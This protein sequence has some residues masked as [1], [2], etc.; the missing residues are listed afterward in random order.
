MIQIS[1]T[2]P[3]VAIAAPQGN[4]VAAGEAQASDFA[5]ALA[6]LLVPGAGKMADPARQVAAEGGKILPE[7]PGG[8]ED[9][10]TGVP[11][12]DA[13]DDGDGADPAFAWFGLAPA[14]PQPATALAVPRPVTV[15]VSLAATSEGAPVATAAENAAPQADLAAQDMADPELASKVAT[16][17]QGAASAP[18]TR[19]PTPAPAPIAVA[20]TADDVPQLTPVPAVRP[21]PAAA[22]LP[23]TAPV[24]R[25]MRDLTALTGATASSTDTAA[26]TPIAVAAPAA[27]QQGA[28]DTR[29]HDWTGAMVEQIEALRDAGPAGETRLQLAPDGLG[30]VDVA[31][32]SDGDRVHVH[33]TTETGAARQLLADA[34]PRLAELAESRGLRLGETSV[35]SGD[36]ALGQQTAQQQQQ[37]QQQ[38]AARTL[39]P[40]SVTRSADAA[41]RPSDQ[42][43][44]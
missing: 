1:S 2:A 24:R 44:A 33:F 37:Q 39:R 20:L 25:T 6:A 18:D 32:R 3:R 22:E 23:A 8:E 4:S 43:V 15:T 13:D 21:E 31:I 17:R 19:A 26:T 27:A 41:D 29:R 35:A 34:Q 28:L 12:S 14:P 40:A 16:D 9:G 30:K 11:D 38:A 5:V 7:S 42:R 36:A 10:Q